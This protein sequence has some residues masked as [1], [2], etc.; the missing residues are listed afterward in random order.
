MPKVIKPDMQNIW[1]ESGSLSI[2]P[3]E[4]ISEGWVVEKPPFEEANF[5]EN[6]QDKGIAYILQQG[7]TEW[8]SLTEYQPS[9]I[10]QY[11]GVVY[12]S[13]GVNTNKVPDVDA[14]WE[15]AFDDFG[16]AKAVSDR[17]DDIEAAA[18]PFNQ[19]ILKE[20]PEADYFA[21]S[22][23]GGHVFQ[24]SL[25]T[26][27]FIDNG[28]ISFKHAG[29]ERAKIKPSPLSDAD[30]GSFIATLDWVRRYVEKIFQVQVGDLYLTLNNYQTPQEVTAA[31]GYGTWV[32]V[33]EGK[34]LV[35]FN[36]DTSNDTPA[37][38]KT[39]NSVFGEYGVALTEAQLAPHQ[40]R[41]PLTNVTNSI[42]TA[43]HT[44]LTPTPSQYFHIPQD[45]KIGDNGYG[46]KKT[47]FDAAG[48]GQAHN[49]VQPSLVVGIWRR[50]G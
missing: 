13:V 25:A 4:E 42:T 6:R 7:I 38:T 35:G 41:M 15:R 31:K 16:S 28:N 19:Y 30:S 1:A 17:L 3:S 44:D 46:K 8:D 45:I 43:E 24:E 27:M 39:I 20:T 36:S 10:I 37:W 49:N 12:K 26:G 2:I 9:S 18:D 23:S 21:A 50:V 29:L 32:R 14:A 47:S 5:I 22:P 34:A 48:G 11:D 33:A 40:H